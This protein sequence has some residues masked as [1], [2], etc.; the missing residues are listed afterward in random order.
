MLL[1]GITLTKSYNRG[2]Y[3]PDNLNLFHPKSPKHFVH[4]EVS[5][6]LQD[7]WHLGWALEV[8]FVDKKTYKY[9]SLN[10]IISNNYFSLVFYICH[11]E[12]CYTITF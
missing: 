2:S 11:S 8:V 7:S 3:E 9:N 4:E 10:T 6:K 1:S 5:I 12:M